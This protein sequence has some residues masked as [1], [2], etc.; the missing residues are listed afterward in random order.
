MLC[1]R[2][3]GLVASEVVEEALLLSSSS[4]LPLSLSLSLLPWKYLEDC[5]V[6]FPRHV[7]S[8]VV[9]VAVAVKLVVVGSVVRLQSF[10]LFVLDW[11]HAALGWE[12]QG[13]E[14]EGQMRR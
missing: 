12:H 9:A 11:P 3:W 4:S 1:Q 7:Q 6:H 13:L 8:Y 5:L 10:Q 14:G 2:Y